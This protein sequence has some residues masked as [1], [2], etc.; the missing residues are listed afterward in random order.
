[1]QLSVSLW[2]Y[3]NNFFGA[4]EETTLLLNHKA[5]MFLSKRK[6]LSTGNEVDLR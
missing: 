6:I 2:D 5:N 1:M 4:V 3:T